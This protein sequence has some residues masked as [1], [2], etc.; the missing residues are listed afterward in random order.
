MP[1]VEFRCMGAEGGVSVAG[2]WSSWAP[3]PLERDGM[4]WSANLDLPPGKHL[5]KFII[6]GSWV[7]DPTRPTETDP[8]GNVNNV[9]TVDEHGVVGEEEESEE[10]EE[11]QRCQCQRINCGDD[12]DSSSDEEGS[13][14]DGDTE[15]ESGDD[16]ERPAGR[17][18]GSIPVGTATTEPD[19]DDLDWG[20]ALDET[21]KEDSR[22]MAEI[23]AEE[24]LPPPAGPIMLSPALQAFIVLTAFCLIILYIGL[25]AGLDYDLGLLDLAYSWVGALLRWYLSLYNAQY[26]KAFYGVPVFTLVANTLACVC[27]AFPAVLA[28]RETHYAGRIAIEAVSTGFAGCL[29]TVSTLISEL[30]SDAIGGLRVRIFY[31]LISFGLAMAVELPI[32]TAHC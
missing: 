10:E 2:S 1:E 19:V 5:Y 28:Q 27:N 18:S 7:H 12:E 4:G 24:G 31:F 8:E 23:A 15:D 20:L 30:Q 11:Q 29:S 16:A 13:E 21:Q 3:L 6:E 32:L 25:C 14:T 9:V 22:R 26:Q 17:S